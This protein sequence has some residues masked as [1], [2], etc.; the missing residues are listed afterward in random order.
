M[1]NKSVIAAACAFA[2]VSVGAPQPASAGV[3]DF[4]SGL[5]SGGVTSSSVCAGHDPLDECHS[6]H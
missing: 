1:K 4:L 3:L 6:S 5:F 2:L